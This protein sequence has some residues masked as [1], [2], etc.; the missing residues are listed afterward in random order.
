MIVVTCC[1]AKRFVVRPC[2]D[3]HSPMEKTGRKT[4][5]DEPMDGYNI[6]LTASQAIKARRLGHG[7][8]AEGVRF[9]LDHPQV[10]A[11]RVTPPRSHP[12]T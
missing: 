9:A 6:R 1:G 4:I 8:M 2:F 10:S 3:L 11:G 12:T 7:N 5:Y